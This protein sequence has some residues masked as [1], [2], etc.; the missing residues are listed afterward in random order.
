MSL[1]LSLT[2]YLYPSLFP[3][4]HFASPSCWLA[5]SI[6]VLSASKACS[7]SFI[8]GCLALFFSVCLPRYPPKEVPQLSILHDF[9]MEFCSLLWS[10]CLRQGRLQCLSWVGTRAVA[11]AGAVDVAAAPAAA[12]FWSCGA[13][14]PGTER[15]W[16][17][18]SQ[19]SY[20]DNHKVGT[21]VSTGKITYR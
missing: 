1:S 2:L 15:A 12:A 4:L 10:S 14:P 3:F 20:Q 19:P 9:E 11:A 13:T 18:Y 17:D 5:S 21:T 7:S 6:P 8:Q 16:E